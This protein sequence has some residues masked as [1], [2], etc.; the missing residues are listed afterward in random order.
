MGTLVFTKVALTSVTVLA[1][2]QSMPPTTT[3][4]QAFVGS[5]V[6]TANPSNM[7]L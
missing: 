2:A 5:A 6:A 1:S 4:T 3:K 7:E